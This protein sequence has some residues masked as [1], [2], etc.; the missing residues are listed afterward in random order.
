MQTGAE[1]ACREI[2]TV[3]LAGNLRANDLDRID[4]LKLDCEGGEYTILE[5]A[6]PATLARVER[7][8]LEYHRGLG[9]LPERLAIAGLRL[10]RHRRDTAHTG[11][12]WFGRPGKD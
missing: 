3:S 8:C 1:P 9:T 7:L 10:L 6:A 4:L 11:L 2:E 12:A 5:G